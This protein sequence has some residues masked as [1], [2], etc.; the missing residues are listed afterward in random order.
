MAGQAKSILFTVCS[1]K[2]HYYNASVGFELCGY[3]VSCVCGPKLPTATCKNIKFSTIGNGS[4]TGVY[5]RTR[6]K[7]VVV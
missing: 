6:L 5:R 4:S 7:T 1:P 2:S 3:A